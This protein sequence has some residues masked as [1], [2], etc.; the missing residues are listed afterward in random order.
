[1][2]K[3]KK[4]L[5]ILTPTL[6]LV[7]LFAVFAIS[8]NN[9]HNIEKQKSQVSYENNLNDKTNSN[10]TIRSSMSY[11]YPSY[12]ELYEESKYVAIVRIESIDG[13]NNYSSVN[14]YYVYPYTYG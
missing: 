11:E 1:M 8:S 2:K 9:Q 3:D 13:A 12:D 14:E 10:Y 4:I 5:K 7:F 6:G